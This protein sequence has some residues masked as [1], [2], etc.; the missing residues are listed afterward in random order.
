MKYLKNILFNQKKNENS[1]IIKCCMRSY[2]CEPIY[3]IIIIIITSHSINKILACFFAFFISIIAILIS[4]SLLVIYTQLNVNW[5]VITNFI[6]YI[7]NMSFSE[8]I[9]E[10]KIVQEEKETRS[11]ANVLFKRLKKWSFII[12]KQKEIIETLGSDYTSSITLIDLLFQLYY[13][14]ITS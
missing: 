10:L 9:S 14:Y 3:E 1:F 12:L 13:L 6:H 7:N 8:F 5:I 4:L 11:D 2:E